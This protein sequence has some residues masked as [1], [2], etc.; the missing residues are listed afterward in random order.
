MW[1]DIALIL[2][3]LTAATRRRGW[4][5]L[6]PPSVSTSPSRHDSTRSSIV[7]QT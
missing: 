7:V 6:S 2:M 5:L 1:Q 3:T 4:G